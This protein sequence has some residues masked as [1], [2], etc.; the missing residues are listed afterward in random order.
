MDEHPASTAA[1]HTTTISLAYST[2]PTPAFHAQHWIEINQVTATDGAGTYTWNTTGLAAG[3]YYVSGYHFDSATKQAIFSY[4][5]APITVGDFALSGP[6]TGVYAAGQS[7]TIQWN[8]ANVDA[9]STISLAYS[10][11]PRVA[12]PRRPLD[13]GRPGYRGQRRGIV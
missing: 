9:G 6:A 13:R 2:N 7:V 11:D 4:L 5:G 12:L 8:A 10:D 3:T 1:G